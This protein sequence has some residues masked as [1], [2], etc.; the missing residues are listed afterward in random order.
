MTFRM[1]RRSDNMMCVGM[2]NQTQAVEI[3]DIQT[4]DLSV[5][6]RCKNHWNYHKAI[7]FVLPSKY[8]KTRAQ[9]D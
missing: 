3:Q 8:I 4:M 5:K 1:L 2:H 6:A 7:L 9:H